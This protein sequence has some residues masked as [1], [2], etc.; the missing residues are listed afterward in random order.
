MLF[1]TK[2]HQTGYKRSHSRLRARNKQP[3]RKSPGAAPL[4]AFKVDLE[5]MPAQIANSR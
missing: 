5:L 3:H 4:C 1:L 2:R